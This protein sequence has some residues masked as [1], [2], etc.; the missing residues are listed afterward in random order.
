MIKWHKVE[1]FNFFYTLC[2]E[3]EL[4][5]WCKKK[6]VPPPE[7]PD[8][9]FGFAANYGAYSFVVLDQKRNKKQW[10]TVGTI[11]HESVHIY[12]ACMKYIGESDTGIEMEAYTIEAIAINLLKDQDALHEKRKE[13][14][15]T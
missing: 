11:I 12:Q 4:K 2:T 1:P 14:L 8:I 10:D 15:Q 6:K 7:I 9:Y 3:E 5:L 13:G